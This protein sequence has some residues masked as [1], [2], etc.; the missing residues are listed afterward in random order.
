MFNLSVTDFVSVLVADGGAGEN[1]LSGLDLNVN[2]EGGKAYTGRRATQ[3]LHGAG[4]TA[5]A[6]LH[7]MAQGPETHACALL[8]LWT[9]LATCS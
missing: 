4:R 5:C 1:D 3:H 8:H 9:F 2:A 7:L 6:K